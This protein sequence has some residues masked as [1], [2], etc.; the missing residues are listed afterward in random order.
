VAPGSAT[1]KGTCSAIGQAIPRPELADGNENWLFQEGRP[2]DPRGFSRS[3]IADPEQDSTPELVA[4][5]V[6]RALAALTPDPAY[7]FG[8]SGGA[9]TGLALAARHP[10]QVHTLIAHKPPLAELL[11]DPAR[12]HAAIDDIYDT[13]RREGQARRGQNSSPSAAARRQPTTR[14]TNPS[15]SSPRPLRNW[16]TANACSLTSSA[17]P[18]S[19]APAL[20]RCGPRPPRIVVGGGR[21]SAGQAAH[22]AAAAL[23]T[24]LGTPLV[25]FPGGHGGFA[26][27][28]G[29]FAQTLR[30]ALTGAD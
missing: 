17:R 14:P 15:S 26:S 7:V 24:Q 1:A 29:P 4:D 30:K 2:A 3:T 22:R 18:P 21:A 8:S 12:V 20:P 6:H 25:E 19:T 10:E 5:D 9:V 23:A 27:E 28:P 16:P 11:P 13:Y